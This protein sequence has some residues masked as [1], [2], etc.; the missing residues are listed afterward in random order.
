MS[1]EEFDASLVHTDPVGDEVLAEQTR[2]VEQLMARPNALANAK[3]H[4]ENELH[5][6]VVACNRIAWR[7]MPAEPRQPTP[8][9]INTL[10]ERLEQ[11]NRHKLMHDA[12][13]AAEQRFLVVKLQEAHERCQAEME[14]EQEE[15]ARQQ[16]LAQEWAEFEAYDEQGKEARFE[17][18]RAS[19]SGQQ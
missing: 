16:Q 4:G 17:T 14:A 15:H 11:E 3:L 2:M 6:L 19:R 8:E 5:R 9:E 13:L 10:L 1:T 7:S 12:K 18:W